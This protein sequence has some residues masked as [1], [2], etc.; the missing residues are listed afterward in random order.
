MTSSYLE[1]IEN[2]LAGFGYNCDKKKGKRQIVI[3][4][5]CDEQGIPLSIE[6][7]NYSALSGRGSL[8]LGFSAVESGSTQK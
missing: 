7:I 5:L 1:G 8:L 3:S 6:V 4:L 2:E